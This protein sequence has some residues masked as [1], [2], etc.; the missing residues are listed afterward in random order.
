MKTRKHKGL[1]TVWLN[2]MRCLEMQCKV[3]LVHLGKQ[4]TRSQALRSSG[5][6][7]PIALMP[8]KGFCRADHPGPDVQP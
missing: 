3:S 5:S 6:S 1:V 8:V 4:A 2:V 7:G